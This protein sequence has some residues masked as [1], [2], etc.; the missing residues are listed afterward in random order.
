[1]GYCV[2]DFD[3]MLVM[4][5]GKRLRFSCLSTIIWKKT[6]LGETWKEARYHS[7]LLGVQDETNALKPAETGT[8][9]A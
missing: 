3:Q 2:V 6:G 4:A 8:A 7:S 9:G 5:D 1:M